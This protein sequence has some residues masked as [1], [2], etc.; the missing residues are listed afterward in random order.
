MCSNLKIV[1]IPASHY[2]PELNF[3]RAELENAFDVY[4]RLCAIRTYR[5][6]PSDRVLKFSIKCASGN[7]Y[8][9]EMDIVKALMAKINIDLRTGELLDIPMQIKIREVGKPE[10]V[11][12]ERKS[13]EGVYKKTINFLK[14][15]K[16]EE[17][18]DKS[19]TLFDEISL[20]G[21]SL[22]QILGEFIDRNI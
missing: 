14:I 10:E 9:Y 13:L 21:K 17:P 8:F 18:I 11:P 7:E 15:K 1:L 2:D 20:D 19:A 16:Q 3:Y 4:H 6:I 5:V 22:N 12:H